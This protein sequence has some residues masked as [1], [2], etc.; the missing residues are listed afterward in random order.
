MKVYV[1]HCD[2]LTER[3][4]LLEI[5]LAKHS[6]DRD[7]EWI[8]D[9][10]KEHPLV[11]EW[12]EKTGTRIPD[13]YISLSLKHYEAYTRMVRDGIPEAILFEDDVIIS[14]Y[15]DIEKIPRECP[16]VKLGKGVPDMYIPLGNTPMVIGNNGGSEACYM[17]REFAEDFLKNL[18]MMWTIDIE[19]HGYLIHKR[20]P[21]VCV[22]MCTQD[23]GAT[24]V[25]ESKDYGMTWIEYIQKWD[26]F[27]KFKY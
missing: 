21:L 18:N 10:P 19:Q 11:Q 27:P 1:L 12:K 4:R 9:F 3:R 25:H 7:V 6:L 2:R 8:T 23:F 20:I 15:F 13:G 17:R 16:F 22:P 26:T 14:D 5:Q 24:S